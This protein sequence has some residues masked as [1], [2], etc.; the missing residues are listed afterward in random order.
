MSDGG[1]GGGG[2]RPLMLL[3]DITRSMCCHPSMRLLSLRSVPVMPA[4]SVDFTTFTWHALLKR[5]R[6]MLL[7]GTTLEEGLDWGLEPDA[8]A[9]GG[10]G[11]T[12]ASAVGGG[13][14]FSMPSSSSSRLATKCLSSMLF[15]RGRGADTADASVLSDPRLYP[16]WAPQPLTVAWSPSPFNRYEMSAT[17]L[18]N[19]Q[20]PCPPIGRML[21]RAYQMH[22][23]G[24]YAHQYAEHGVGA[25]EFEEAFG[26]VE[27]VLAAYRTM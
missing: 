27:D 6:Q 1:G 18:S 11:R 15:L 3:H 4:R 2:G 23:A 17:L 21:A 5:T 25:G 22:A 24:A 13:S 14:P 10:F 20:T 26:R 7:T 9:G 16:R 12:T 19:C 8:A